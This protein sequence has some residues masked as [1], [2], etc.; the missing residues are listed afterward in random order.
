MEF[1]DVKNDIAFRK[2]FGNDNRKETLISFLNAVLAFRGK[3]KIVEVKIINPYQLPK[4]RGGKVSI[5]DIKATDQIGRH[6][7][8]EMQ[9]GELDG[10]AKRVLFYFSKSYS[11]QIKRGDF[12]RQLK[13]VIFIGILDY[14]F[15]DNPKYISRHRILD[16]ETHEHLLQDVE[17]NFVELPKFNKELNELETLT[18][19]WI[20]FIKNAENL[21]VIPENVDDE[22]LKSAYQ[23]ANKHTWTAEELEAYE[24]AFMREEDE[25]A[26]LDQAEKRGKNQEKIEIAKTMLADN[27]PNEKI[28][29][30]TG[31]TAEQIEQLRDEKE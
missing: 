5:I 7:I 30:Y 11:E 29:R 27:E 4:L 12:Y 21:D 3:Q 31:L 20:Y 10:F 19:K 24:Y 9:V 28:A 25:R 6:Y 17:F 16:V 26:K 8:V 22:G 18:E 2:I 15:S 14:A 13:P 1:A 23:E